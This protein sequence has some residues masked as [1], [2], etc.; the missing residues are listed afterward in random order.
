MIDYIRTE[1]YNGKT[2]ENV[3][4]TMLDGFLASDPKK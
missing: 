1:R 4:G 2:P 3:L